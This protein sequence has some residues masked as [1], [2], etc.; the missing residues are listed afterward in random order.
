MFSEEFQK[1][2]FITYADVDIKDV[3][4]GLV[5]WDSDMGSLAIAHSGGQGVYNFGGFASWNPHTKLD[6][7]FTEGEEDNLVLSYLPV[8]FME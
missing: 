5:L 3:P 6:T 8:E 7:F 1:E 4:E 2:V